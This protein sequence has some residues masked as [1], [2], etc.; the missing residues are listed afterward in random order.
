[1]TFTRTL[2]QTLMVGVIASLMAGCSETPGE[3]YDFSEVDATVAGFM[4]DYS[5][6]EGVTLAVVRTDEGQIY[7]KGYGDFSADRISLITSTGKVLAAGVILTLVDDGLLDVDRPVAEYLDWGDYHASVTIRHLLSMMAG[8]PGTSG[9]TL[10]YTEPCVVDSAATLQECGQIVFR[11]ESQFIPPGQEFRYSAGAWQLAGAVAEVVS[12]KTWAELV[13]EKLIAPC[14][15]HATG[16]SNIRP[17]QFDGD[18]TNLPETANP[19]LGG[20]AYSGVSDYS[21]VLLMHL[22]RGLCGQ[23]RVLSSEMVQLMQEDLVPEGAAGLPPIWR[24]EAI[25]YGMGWW[26]YEDQPGLLV[27]SGGFGARA[28]LHPEEGWGAIMIIETESEDGHEL[29]NGLVPAIRE[30]LKN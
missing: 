27:D 8:I 13:E 17:D 4:A 20:G 6:V 15:L 1:M 5:D 12:G 24:P 26:K 7:E 25:N 30:A 29:F 23:L 18:P 19:R 10:P 3:K 9:K 21:K 11:N 16:F 14:A 28:I 2:S 22:R